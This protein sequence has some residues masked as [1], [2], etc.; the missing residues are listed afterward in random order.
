VGGFA[1]GGIV[2]TAPS[3]WNHMWELNATAPFLAIR[4]AVPLLRS[5]GSGRIVNVAAAAALEGG[6]GGM[7]A[8]LATKAAVVSLTRN[9]AAELGPDGIMVNAVAPTIIDTPSNREAMP[10]SD[11]SAWLDAREIAAVIRFLAGPDAAV[12]NGN[13]L[14]LKKSPER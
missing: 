7:S 1:G 10:G 11:R 12:V 6:R 2:D 5:G 4:S 13:V 8:Y 14:V 9:L 3:A